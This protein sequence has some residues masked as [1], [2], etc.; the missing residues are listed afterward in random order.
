LVLDAKKKS[1]AL[2]CKVNKKFKNIQLEINSEDRLWVYK[3]C[4]IY[5]NVWASIRGKLREI[6]FL[7]LSKYVDRSQTRK[8]LILAD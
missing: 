1:S 6:L 5:A 4:Y 7:I 2:L 8:S 3:S